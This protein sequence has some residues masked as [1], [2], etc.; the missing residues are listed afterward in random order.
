MS[1]HRWR[2]VTLLAVLLLTACDG[3][4]TSSTRKTPAPTATFTVAP[5]AEV[6]LPRVESGPVAT[7]T[8]APEA[9]SPLPTPTAP[10]SP[11]DAPTAAP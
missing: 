1:D 11:V 2:L 7:D 10:P 6:A 5:T 3:G 8:P 9:Q 4:D